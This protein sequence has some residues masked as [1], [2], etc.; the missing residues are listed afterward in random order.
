MQLQLVGQ[1]GSV[2]LYDLGA[3]LADFNAA[4]A[5]QSP[6]AD[7]SAPAQGWLQ[8]HPLTLASGTAYGGNLAEQ[9]GRDG[10]LV[11]ASNAEV[12]VDLA[13]LTLSAAATAG[14]DYLLGTFGN[15]SLSGG[16]GNDRLDAGAGNDTLDGGAGN[17]TLAGGSGADVYCFGAGDGVDTVM[18]DDTTPGVNDAVQFVGTVTRQDVQFLQDGNDLD[19][20][21]N[22]T[23][24]KLVIQDWYLGSAHHVE[25][26]R[27]TD[28]SVL[29][30]SQVQGLV[31][32]M[33]SFSAASGTSAGA[34]PDGQAQR[35]NQV[36]TAS[37]LV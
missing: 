7:W 25:E 12:Q 27:F 8:G 13:P 1:D 19:L 37:A 20:L 6:Q 11:V 28:G 35:A 5:A 33:A 2:S 9:Y 24:D 32:A 36:L 22:G 21:I 29:M 23:A 4:V 15:D 18:E 3:A 31:S 26:F 17:D 10:S 16:A 30:D 14:D 34:S